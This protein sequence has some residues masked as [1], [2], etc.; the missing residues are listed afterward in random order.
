MEKIVCKANILKR[1]FT[2]KIVSSFDRYDEMKF[3]YINMI[4]IQ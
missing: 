4:C 3:D 2:N 1:S